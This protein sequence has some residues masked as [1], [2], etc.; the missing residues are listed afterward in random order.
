MKRISMT[1]VSLLASLSFLL[2]LSCSNA[3]GSASS[4]EEMNETLKTIFARTSVRSYT[5]TPI[6]KDTLE[7]LV[8]AGMA[9]PTAMN[10]QPWQFVIVTD[11]DSMASL[12][13]KL[14]Y[15]KML[16][17]ATAAIVVAGNPEVSENNWMIDCS[18]VTENILLAAQSVGIGAVWTAVYPYPERIDAVREAFGIP[19]PWIPLSLV[20]MGYPDKENMPKDKWKPENIHYNRW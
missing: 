15:A 5:S 14:P 1:S 8:K 18:A 7:L 17:S 19:H 12:S 2:S 9:S 20:P 6:S 10:R 4:P 11:K 3:T 13:E 16:K